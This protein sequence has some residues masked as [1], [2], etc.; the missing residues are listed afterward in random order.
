M[1]HPTGP[2]RILPRAALI[3]AAALACAAPP[4]NARSVLAPF[5]TP[6]AAPG[7]TPIGPE[8]AARS[9]AAPPAP[10]PEE[11]PALLSA[12]EVEYDRERDIV[13][14]RGSVEIIQGGRA[15][16]ADLITF[17]RARG[18]VNASGNVSL[19]EPTGDAV[20]ADHAE[21]TEDLR[22]GA[23]RNFRALLA[24][25]SRLAGAAGQRS[26]GKLTT[27]RKVVYS[28]CAPCQEDPTR[29]P[30]W[31]IKAARATHDQ[32]KATVRYRDAWVEI[33]GVPVL[34]TPYLEH[35][36]GTVKR[37]SGL[38]LPSFGA[39]NVLGPFYAQPL[40]LT[41]GRSADLTLE[42]MLFA[43]DNPLLAGEYQQQLRDGAFTLNASLTNAHVYDDNATR[44][45]RDTPRGH[46]AG[47]GRFDLDDDWRW[48]FDLARASQDTYLLRY[49]LFDRFRF[50]DRNTLTSRAFVEGFDG[51]SHALAQAY[52]F[53]GLRP[54]DDPGLAP[55]VL[56]MVDVHWVGTP[57]R[58]GGYVTARSYTYAVHR[59]EGTVAQ[60]SAG[61]LGYTLPF[62]AS[63]GEVWTLGASLQGDLF[64]IGDPGQR[65]DGFRP[66]QDG[67]DARAFPQV[68][69]GWRWPLMRMAGAQRLIVEPI[70]AAVIAPRVGT[71]SRFPNEDSRAIDLDD[72][73]LFRPNRYTGLDRLEGGPRVTYGVNV[74]TRRAD[75]GAR[76]AMFLGQSYRF[77]RDNSVPFETGLSSNASNIVGRLQISPHEWLTGT[78]R[79]QTDQE[80]YSAARNTGSLQLG[81]EA[82]NVTFAYTFV[83]RASQPTL[84]YDLEQLTTRISAHLDAHW[85]FVVRD[86]RAVGEESGQLRFNA[87]LI[88]ED[89][90]F[91]F[92]V[93]VQRRR[94]G[95]RDDPPDSSI[96]L[97]VALRNLGEARLR[98]Q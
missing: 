80:T 26:G 41:L 42:P 19:V 24:D 50:I 11:V 53:Q 59:S 10:A 8:P 68:S 84:P 96:V 69:L 3:V 39:S 48:G 91:L 63:T 70:V 16:R 83:D 88:Y 9:R 32:E 38:L 75:S 89:E 18:V 61:V 12:D 31:Q 36:D 54:E 65:D 28:P 55:F 85:R 25:W 14:A 78:W 51:R 52:A 87:A 97:R 4:A 30:L 37:Q 45:G 17:D 47:K 56:P 67:F 72:T 92:G 1:S 74:A 33:A 71:Q 82:F 58:R 73:N 44:T 81:P 43:K 20:F 77:Q 64:H 79:F 21:L 62:T 13:T 94:V 34:Y 46:I 93:D 60:R 6:A 49:K 29:A 27:L 90:C 40:Y 76:A 86:T 2:D 5:A 35:P 7:P 95:T 23:I 15:L 66:S 57:D 22:E 98:A